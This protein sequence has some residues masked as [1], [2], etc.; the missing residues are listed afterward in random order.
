MKVVDD[1]TFKEALQQTIQNDGTEYIFEAFQNDMDEQG[2]LVY[3][4]NIRIFNDFT[5]WFM[6]KLGFAWNE[7]D[8]E[9]MKGY[10]AYFRELGYLKV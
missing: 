1:A 9:Y 5:M 3:D 2:R 10:V 8:V 4:S 6:E 7:I